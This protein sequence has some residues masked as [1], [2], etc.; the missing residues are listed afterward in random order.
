MMDQQ[1][2][3][4]DCK[5]FVKHCNVKKIEIFKDKQLLSASVQLPRVVDAEAYGQLTHFYREQIQSAIP[6]IPASFQVELVPIYEENTPEAICQ[7]P[8]VLW[9]LLH[10]HNLHVF[11]KLQHM[12]EDGAVLIRCSNEIAYRTRIGKPDFA[13][14]CEQLLARICGQPLK[15]FTRYEEDEN[16]APVP[17]DYFGPSKEWEKLRKEQVHRE[18]PAP[19]AHGEKRASVHSAVSGNVLKGKLIKAS[20]V[21]VREIVDEE[22][23]ACLA[24]TIFGLDSRELKSGRSLITFALTD[25]TDSL[26]CKVFSDKDEAGPLLDALKSASA[27]KV[28]GKVQYDTY[29]DEIGMICNDINVSTLACRVDNA[30]EKRVELHLHT[31]MS[32]MDG[33]NDVKDLVKLASQL[34]HSAMAITDH[35]VVQA[36]PDAY[37]AGQ[38]Y[39]VKIIYGVE[40]YIID[41]DEPEVNLKQKRSYHCIVLAK[42]MTGLKN[43]YRLITESELRYFHRRPRI[44]KR[45]INYARE[46]LVVGSACEAGELMQYL[47]HNPDDEAGLE[48]LAEFYDYIEIQP[49]ANNFFMIRNGIAED[50]EALRELNRRLFE[51]GKRMHKPV[52]AT[53]DVHFANADDDIYR[54]IIMKSRGFKDAEQ[55]APLYYRTTDEMLREFAYLG[56]DEAYN[57]VVRNPNAIIAD[58]EALTPVP[59]V[60]HAPEIEGAE[61]QIKELTLSKA[62]RLYGEELPELIQKR[63]DKE[64]KSIIGNGYAVLYLIAHKLVK[65][66]NDNGY[67]VGSRGSVGSSVVAYFTNIT[68]VNALPPHYRCPHCQYSQ[69]DE[70]GTYGAGV[71]MPDA[72]CPVCGTK[73][74]KDGFD[75]PF[76]IFLGFKGDKIP[77]IDL[78]F[79][80]D[81][82]AGAHAYTE[83]LFG[84]DNVFR[85]GTLATVAEKTAYGYVR[86]YFNDINEKRR[87][88]E[89][90]RLKLGCTGVKRTTGQHPG[91]LVVIPK[92]VDA[93]DFTPLQRPADDVKT[94]TVTTHFDYH[95]IDQG[96]VKLDILGHDDPTVI[97]MLG[98][99]TGIDPTT[100]PLDDPATLSLFSSTEALD[101]TPERLHSPVATYG[102]PEF[103]TSFVRKMLEDTNPQSFSDL[104]RISGFSHGTDV[105]LNNA[106]DIIVNKIA[107]V[108]QTISTRDDIML[109]LIQRGMDESLSFKIME[110]VRKGRGLKEDQEA[111]MHES[112]I[113]QWFIDSCKK[114][115]YLFPKAHAVAYVMMAYRIAWFKINYPLAF[116]A[117]YFSVRG[118][119]DFDI[120]IIQQGEEGVRQ[121]ILDLYAQGNALTAKEKSKI[122]VLEV[123]L[124][125]YTRGFKVLPVSLEQ[126]SATDFIISE[127]SLLPPFISI[128]GLGTSQAEDIVRGREQKAYTSL[129]DLKK[130]G[131]TGD[132]MIEKFKQLGIVE[133]LPER[134]QIA[135]F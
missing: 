22:K 31:Q 119:E 56:E 87:E 48:K 77:D 76:E 109:F 124:E 80:G 55:Q 75:I 40:A 92:G 41:D 128:D 52:V 101:V 88:A 12:P 78:N 5:D 13:K 69:F 15:V 45:L 8:D 65:N 29:S 135:F 113:P 82:Q 84:K 47:I 42:N 73:L 99:L 49:I 114:I 44:P 100:V 54:A 63:I 37:A 6:N 3:Q 132:T 7:A 129:E 108:S 38:K 59:T 118:I 60:L 18:A 66:S 72:N 23:S 39:G 102:I 130:R 46:G 133:Q 16:L 24:G 57:V 126:S 122:T 50:E 19:R 107:P 121:A 2:A 104:L 35:G 4:F 61:D 110:G 53:C 30:T 58:F 1:S 51:L 20:P 103:N 98:D 97:K 64:L 70:S 134:D 25:H 26:S 86:N 127:D 67:V 32:S 131:K 112:N 116:Y 83:E 96:L 120:G 14:S 34:G 85:A 106:Q 28:R 9:Q 117:S 94:E 43:L 81:Y 36:F 125:L 68:E 111:A 89:I 90:N 79:S 91:G 27:I 123:A 10:V 21:E 17:D 62:H 74:E 93:H 95:K 11:L 105:W 71:D 115:K 33:M